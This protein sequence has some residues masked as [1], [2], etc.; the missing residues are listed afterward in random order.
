MKKVSIVFDFSDKIQLKYLKKLR[1][2]AETKVS[3]NK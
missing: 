1:I 2:S 3:T